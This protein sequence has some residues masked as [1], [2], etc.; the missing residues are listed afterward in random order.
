MGWKESLLKAGTK[1]KGAGGAAKGKLGSL[2]GKLSSAKGKLGGAAGKAGPAAGRMGG[3]ARR[4]SGGVRRATPTPEQIRG[5]GLKGVAAGATVA[6]A[7][8]LAYKGAKGAWRIS[9]KL[10]MAINIL[11]FASFALHFLD[12]GP[13]GIAPYMFSF[14]KTRAIILLMFAI[15]AWLFIFSQHEQ[16]IGDMKALV[17]PLVISA[18]A[19][20][21]PLLLMNEFI[22]NLLNIEETI[23]TILI[24]VPVW[25]IVIMFGM[26]TTR[27]VR[28]ARVAY[29]FFVLVLLIP[30]IWNSIAIDFD[31]GQMQTGAAGTINTIGEKF[32]EGLQLSWKVIVGIPSKVRKTAEK[33]IQY[34]TGDY[35]T[36]RVEQGK[37]R[38]IGVYLKDV[39]PVTREFYSNEVVVVW[40]TLLARTLDPDKTITV[41]ASCWGEKMEDY[42]LKKE[43]GDADPTSDDDEFVMKTSTEEEKYITCEFPPGFFEEGPNSIFVKADFNFRTMSYIKG[44]FMNLET[45]RSMRREGID[46][47]DQYEIKDKKPSATYTNGPISLGMETSEVPMG[48]SPTSSQDIKLGITLENGWEGKIKE[49]NDIIIKIPESLEIIYC[50]HAFE[51]RPCRED[52][53]EDGKY[54]VV[55]TIKDQAEEG[56]LGLNSIKNVKGYHSIACRARPKNINMLMGSYP[57]VT[58]YFKTTVDY[59]YELEKSTS[60][61]IKEP[62]VDENVTPGGEGQEKKAEPSFSY[63]P[64]SSSITLDKGEKEVFSVTLKDPGDISYAWGVKGVKEETAPDQTSYIFSSDEAGSAVITFQAVSKEGELIEE[65]KW[66]VEV[67]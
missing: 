51:K 16:G 54:S 53:C 25:P 5:A 50:D 44:Y 10:F 65:R 23:K 40:A 41:T 47:L 2:A 52:E 28:V 38:P 57:L 13:Y 62:L 61:M 27:V 63:S 35:Y 45:L 29:V 39:K 11:L 8:S 67:V 20:F 60:V 48:V 14:T 24:L 30:L 64:S 6:G 32:K 66:N 56:R 7:G 58:K 4:F 43:K 9:Q 34:A 55:Y 15:F 1:F 37:N 36:G 21:L 49:V 46:P 3:A 33:Q 17:P 59:V 31:I 42:E 19:F 18:I 22:F 12:V 26:P